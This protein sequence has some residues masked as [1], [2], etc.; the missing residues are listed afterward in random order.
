M[1]VVFFVAV[2][3]TM[4]FLYWKVV[5]ALSQGNRACATTLADSYVNSITTSVAAG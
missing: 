2:L 4:I 5:S 1:L 3:V